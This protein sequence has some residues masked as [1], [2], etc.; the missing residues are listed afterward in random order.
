[1]TP[2]LAGCIRSR[3]VSSNERELAME[4]K[5][6]FCMELMG[7]DVIKDNITGLSVPQQRSLVYAYPI[8]AMSS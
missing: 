4:V 3:Y 6:A 8:S 2:P 7:F 5:K 1:M